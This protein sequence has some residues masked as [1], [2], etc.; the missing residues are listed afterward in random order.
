MCAQG[1]WKVSYKS[2]IFW[3]W[4][5]QIGGMKTRTCL[6][7]R[8]TFSLSQKTLTLEMHAENTFA[9]SEGISSRLFTVPLPGFPSLHEWFQLDPKVEPLPSARQMVRVTT[10]PTDFPLTLYDCVETRGRCWSTRTDD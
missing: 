6:Q 8:S 5:G 10:L 2:V 1:E 4:L 9:L 3:E 7:K